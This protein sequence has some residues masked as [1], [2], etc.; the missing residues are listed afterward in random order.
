MLI[1]II[2]KQLLI[3]L[4]LQE[5]MFLKSGIELNNVNKLTSETMKM[6]KVCFMIGQGLRQY[7]Q[8]YHQTK[9]YHLK[10]ILDRCLAN[11]LIL[12]LLNA[13]ALI[14]CW[15]VKNVILIVKLISTSKISKLTLGL[16]KKLLILKYMKNFLQEK[17]KKSY[18]PFY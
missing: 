10:V 16:T 6:R 3:G 1:C 12:S 4:Y 17:I 18:H 8:I 13:I 14:L 7:V 5:K 9:M 15:V 11:T 2:N